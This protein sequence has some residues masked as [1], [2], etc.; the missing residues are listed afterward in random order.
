M[1]PRIGTWVLGSVG[2]GIVSLLTINAYRER[3]Q[4]ESAQAGSSH[5]DP[6]LPTH[7][8]GQRTPL[9]VMFSI[10][11]EGQEVRPS[12]INAIKQLRS[13]FPHL[14]IYHFLSAGYFARP[15]VDREALMASIRSVVRADD[16]VGIHFNGWRSIIERSGVEFKSRTNFWGAVPTDDQC[17]FNDCGNDIPLNEYSFAEIDRI[18]KTSLDVLDE[19]GFSSINGMMV[20][21]WLAHETVMAA[22]AKNGIRF[23][24]SQVWPS[25]LERKLKAYPL[26]G[27]LQEVWGGVRE[28][29]FAVA[30][31]RMTRFGEIAELGNSATAVDFVDADHIVALFNRLWD[32]KKQNPKM[33]ALFHLSMHQE[34]AAR[35]ASRFEMAIV[36]VQEEIRS[37]NI[38]ADLSPRAALFGL[39][40]SALLGH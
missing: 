28:E 3:A 27:S 1:R 10:V 26:F 4:Q 22:A 36:K 13:Q 33:P 30:S 11:W 23:S 16:M 19:A 9:A 39:R 21:G 8:A 40:K 20:G 2:L 31:T 6:I 7:S 24:F 35:Y 5:A 17:K 32:M 37:N 18:L 38:L 34:T 14:P 29:N 12:N 15:T 25:L